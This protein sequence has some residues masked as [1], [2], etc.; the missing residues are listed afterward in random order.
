MKKLL[1]LAGKPIGSCEIVNYAKEQGAYVIVTDY[2]P[3]E[4]SAAKRL[5]DECW[6]VST[7]DTETLVRLVKEHH[8]DG[9]YTGV[10][11]FNI[12]KMIEVCTEAGPFLVL[13]NHNTDWD[14]LLLACAFPDYMS[15]VASETIFRWRFAGKL[16]VWLMDWCFESIMTFVYGLF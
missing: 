5:A 3:K 1:V 13:C 11:E 12:R 2:L 15:Y 6:D 10:H 8:V 16:I 4:M 9:I 14:P 7:A